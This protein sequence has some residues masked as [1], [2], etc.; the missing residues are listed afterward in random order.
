M[1]GV[2]SRSGTALAKVATQVIFCA[3]KTEIALLMC[4]NRTEALMRDAIIYK[5]LKQTEWA[6]LQSHG[7]FDG[8]A[9]DKRDGFIHMSTAA[10]LQGT[11]DKHY[12]EGDVVI[13]AAVRLADIAPDVKWEV[14][15][16]GAEFPHIYAALPLSAVEQ[17]WALS[18]DPKGRYAPAKYIMD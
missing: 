16:G 12:T 1:Q 10:Q 7:S 11:L 4:A 13:L 5:I 2:A 8:S 15:R 6:T 17:H 9:H 18:P 14:S 3:Q